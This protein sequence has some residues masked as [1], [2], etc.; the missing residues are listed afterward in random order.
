MDF[1]KTF[2]VISLFLYKNSIYFFILISYLA[3]LLSSFI[4]SDSF[5]VDSNSFWSHRLYCPWNFPGQ[6]ESRKSPSAV[7]ET[8]LSHKGSPRILE[9]AAYPF[10]S[11]SSQPRNWTRVSCIAGGFFTNWATREAPVWKDTCSLMFTA[12]PSAIVRTWKQPK[13]PLTNE[14]IKMWYVYTI[15]YYLAI[16]KEWNI[17]ICSSTNEPRDYYGLLGWLRVKK[18]WL[19]CGRPGF[20]PWVGKIPWRWEWLP[21]PVFLPR[22][23]HGERSLG[24]YSPW[25][26]KESD[27]E[28]LT[29]SLSSEIIILSDVNHRAKDKY[30]MLSLTSGIYK[31]IETNLFIKL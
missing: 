1:Y 13:C 24:G 16:I 7:R 21:N 31:I 17:A 12:A 2:S 10:S 4:S 8:Q 25:G 15:H 19:Q 30:H 11:G 23:F 5:Y 27:T 14:W 9:W 28:Q 3:T 20:N 22:E 6:N 29:L 18:I 26:H